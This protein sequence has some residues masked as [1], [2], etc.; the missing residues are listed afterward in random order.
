[1]S[2]AGRGVF[3]TGTDTEVGKTVVAAA[4]VR[5]LVEAGLKVAPMKPVAAGAAVTPEGPRN[6][7]ALALMAAAN[8]RNVYR[9]VNPYCLELA[10]SPHIAAAKAGISVEVT[11]ILSAFA[12]LAATAD[13]VVVE[14]A[15]GWYAPLNPTQTMADLA[16]ALNLPVL[17]VVGLRLGCLNHA[18]LTAEAVRAKGLTLAGWVANHVQ[19]AFEHAEENI[20]TLEARLGAP[21][22]S[23]IPYQPH[24]A[25]ARATLGGITVARIKEVCGL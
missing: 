13:L 5:A 19:P 16:S 12:E 15:G 7:D 8:T 3:I 10:A 23:R 24:D 6:A 2:A 1:M 14:G 17:L 25:P 21:L 20:A 9:A 18:L 11:T 4:L 22:L